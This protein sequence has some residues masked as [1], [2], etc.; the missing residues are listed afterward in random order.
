[1]RVPD[2]AE[3]VVLAAV[4]REQI[5]QAAGLVALG[6]NH[7]VGR[8]VGKDEHRF[9]AFGS[10]GQNAFEPQELRVAHVH[11]IYALLLHAEHDERIAVDHLGIVGRGEPLAEKRLGEVE[12]APLESVIIALPVADVVVAHDRQD[13][14]A[15]QEPLHAAMEQEILE[16]LTVHGVVAQE[17][18]RVVAALRFLQILQRLGEDPVTRQV[19]ALDMRVGKHRKVQQAFVRL[20][21]VVRRMRAH[22]DKQQHHGR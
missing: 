1:M 13:F 7:V 20:L 6:V 12:P 8:I 19:V 4:L 2:E 17:Q 16:Q 22:A 15:A 21:H 14:F 3:D 9:A 18:D 10:V 11:L 5:G